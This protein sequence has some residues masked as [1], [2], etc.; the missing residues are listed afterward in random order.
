VAE[1]GQVIWH[2]E[3]QQEAL[4]LTRPP[5]HQHITPTCTPIAS[6]FAVGERVYICNEVKQRKGQPLVS[7]KD[8]RAMVTRINVDN[9]SKIFIVTD[10]NFHTWR[11][12]H[13]LKHL[14]TPGGLPTR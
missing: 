1:E 14:S 8:R 5:Q 11:L 12:Q 2:V 9:P 7:Q 13:H 4:T 10:N 3:V 6:R